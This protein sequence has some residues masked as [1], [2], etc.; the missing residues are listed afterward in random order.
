LSGALRFAAAGGTPE[1]LVEAETPRPTVQPA[2][3]GASRDYQA[4]A[5]TPIVN[6]ALRGG[7]AFVRGRSLFA[8][9]GCASCHAFAGEAGGIGPDLNT[10]GGRYGVYEI[11]QAILEPSQ[12]IS[13]LFTA[14]E[15]RTTA[16]RVLVGRVARNPDGSIAI[17]QS[18]TVDPVSKKTSWA[19]DRAVTVPSA[20]IAA[21]ES[22]PVSPMPAGL[23]SNLSEDEIADL[24]AY[25]IST[26]NPSN[27]VFQPV[28][29][30]P[31]GAR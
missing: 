2:Q 12:V 9:A 31:A 29:A 6:R 3:L 7:R 8:A 13:D 5:L 28:A 22:Y 10:V 25:L 14:M 11:L 16:G 23:I 30:S 19:W 4:E 24:I 27:R 26:G 18:T 15:V 21:M 1:I 20:E 17:A